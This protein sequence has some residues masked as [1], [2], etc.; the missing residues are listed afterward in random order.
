[1]KFTRYFLLIRH[2][3]D[4]TMVTDEW[5]Q[6]AIGSPLKEVRQADGRIRGWAP[7]AEMGGRFLRFI[8]LEDGETVHNAFVDRSFRP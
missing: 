2:R 1:M 6:R 8:L 7:I 5:I 3:P 4:R